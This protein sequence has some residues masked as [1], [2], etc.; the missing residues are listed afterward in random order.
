MSTHINELDA[1]IIAEEQGWDYLPACDETELLLADA[2]QIKVDAN[3]Q[4][5]INRKLLRRD[6]IRW[7]MPLVKDDEDW[8]QI[9]WEL[10]NHDLFSHLSKS[11]TV[12]EAS[13]YYMGIIRFCEHACG[14]N[15]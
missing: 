5:K 10:A 14:R 1:A 8:Q 11:M 7:A 6:A 4:P 13:N 3:Q 2:E 15:Q 9:Q 12:D